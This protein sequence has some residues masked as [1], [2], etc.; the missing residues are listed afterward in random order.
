MA[1]DHYMAICK[2]LLH[3]NKMSKYVC[4]PPSGCQSLYIW[5]YKWSAQII[6]T[7]HLSF[8]GPSE[9]NNFD[10]TSLPLLVLACSETYVKEIAMFVEPHYLLK[11]EYILQGMK[12]NVGIVGF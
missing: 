1:Y 8:C 5:L 9:I 12:Q 7:L 3:C 4:L 11:L 6:P 2:P 10:C